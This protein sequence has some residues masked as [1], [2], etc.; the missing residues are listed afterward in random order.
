MNRRAVVLPVFYVR[1]RHGAA[2]LPAFDSEL[3]PL[4][5]LGADDLDA[6]T[7]AVQRAI[8]PQAVGWWILAGLTALAGLAVI[9]Q[10]TARQFVTDQ[11]DHLAL[12]AVGLR[13]RQFV[14]V[15][16]AR[17]AI[18]GALGAAGAAGLAGCRVT[19][20]TSCSAPSRCAGPV[21]SQE[22]WSGS[23]S[24]TR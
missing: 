9:G 5:T 19:T 15:G 3:R 20:A 10:A 2:D 11:D 22:A 21:R 7:A 1:L 18:I 16:L 14:A 8:S 24:L 13:G 6:D 12:A 23:L 17:A 4:H